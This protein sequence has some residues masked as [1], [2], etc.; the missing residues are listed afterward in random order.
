VEEAR[1]SSAISALQKTD[2]SLPDLAAQL[3][4]SEQSAFTRAF[5]RWT[6]TTPKRYRTQSITPAADD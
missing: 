1:R 4:Y 6:G 5:R 2:T 3:G